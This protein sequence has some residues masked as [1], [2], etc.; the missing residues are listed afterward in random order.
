MAEL[1]LPQKQPTTEE[2]ALEVIR[3]MERT[4]Q[5]T[6]GRLRIYDYRE[7][8]I[9]PQGVEWWK[10]IPLP[11][12]L[13]PAPIWVGAPPIPWALWEMV[14]PSEKPIKGII[15]KLLPK[16]IPEAHM[17]VI[18]TRIEGTYEG[19]LNNIGEVMINPM[20][21]IRKW[22][23]AVKREA[24][25][26]WDLLRG[27]TKPNEQTPPQETSTF[28]FNFRVTGLWD[29]L[30]EL[31][32]YLW[33]RTIDVDWSADVHFTGYETDDYIVPDYDKHFE[34]KASLPIETLHWHLR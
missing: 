28:T 25:K 2:G 11:I 17:Y 10:F 14:G 20:G 32:Q 30:C 23:Y 7:N 6:P 24:A 4:P 27:E 5:G 18:G 15:A 16:R 19:E 31:W 26:T 21:T 13:L 3:I 22:L 1:I 33:T 12:G 29:T 8:F 34:G 9:L